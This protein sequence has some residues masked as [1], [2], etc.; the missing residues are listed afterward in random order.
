MRCKER[1]QEMDRAVE[2]DG[3]NR[4]SLLCVK[5]LFILMFQIKAQ[6]EASV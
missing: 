6:L 4:Y 5:L 1:K 3:I 2:S